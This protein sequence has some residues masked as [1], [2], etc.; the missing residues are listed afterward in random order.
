MVEIQN[1][2]STK[3]NGSDLEGPKYYTDPF[4]ATFQKVLNVIAIYVVPLII[5]VGLIGNGISIV[6]FFSNTLRK[7]SSSIYL[8][9]LA[10]CDNGFLFTLVFQWL[11]WFDIQIYH[12]NGACQ[13][14]T[15]VSN[16]C[17]FLSVWYV[18]S[19]TVERYIAVFYPLKRQ[20]LCTP[21]RSKIVVC[22]LAVASCLYYS[23]HVWTSTITVMY[24][25]GVCSP[26]QEYFS[27]I[28]KMNHIDTFITFIVPFLSISYMNVRIMYKITRLYRRQRPR[29]DYHGSF[30]NMASMEDSESN[31]Q[32]SRK[33]GEMIGESS[34]ISH[35]GVQTAPGRS[36][37]PRNSLRFTGPDRRHSH[38]L[39]ITRLLL[40]VSTTFLVL[41]LPSHAIRLLAYGVVSNKLVLW[42]EFCQLL[43]YINFSINIFLYSVC[44]KSFRQ[45]FWK[46]FSKLFCSSGGNEADECCSRMPRK[47]KARRGTATDTTRV[48]LRLHV[49]DISC[50]ASTRGN[51]TPAK[52]DI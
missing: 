43:Y 5:F 48:T 50:D 22:S 46:S 34:P 7:S 30:Q 36:S 26:K 3:N 33:S 51:S 31:L 47:R 8:A 40:V 18:V 19:F 13:I 6:V 49:I 24:D 27:F 17:A 29:S 42:Q 45:A 14:F 32:K 15:Y 2:N 35:N 1:Y 23:Y 41:N 44:G 28:I 10:I 16:V 39:K 52:R 20:T 21:T 9:A 12:K 25:N 11:V 4:E 38:Q 37:P